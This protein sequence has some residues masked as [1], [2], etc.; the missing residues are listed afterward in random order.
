M[1]D[2]YRRTVNESDDDDDGH[3]LS[4]VKKGNVN[5]QQTLRSEGFDKNNITFETDL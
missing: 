5:T 4:Q 3:Y 1:A 2:R